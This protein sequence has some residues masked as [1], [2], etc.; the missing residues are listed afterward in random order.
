MST[1]LLKTTEEAATRAAGAALAPLL[2]PGDVLVLSGD[3][4]A[5]KTQLV[6]GIA[7]GLD[8]PETVTSPTFNI[9]LVHQGSLPLYHV[10]LYRLDRADQLEDIDFFGTVEAGGV[11]VVEWGDRFAEVLDVSTLSVELH[12]ESDL[13]RLLEVG[14]RGPRGAE[15]ASE[16]A[17]ACTALPGVT[18]R[19]ASPQ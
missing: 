9:L 2:R 13:E 12:I 8:V 18:I 14:W 10:D 6:K 11:T 4:G 17:R 7:R 19:E 5:G 1:L 3:L 15:L 16:W